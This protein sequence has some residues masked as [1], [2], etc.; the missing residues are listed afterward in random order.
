MG[1]AKNHVRAF[2]EDNLRETRSGGIPGGEII[3]SQE[4]LLPKRLRRVDNPPAG[5]IHRRQFILGRVPFPVRRDWTVIQLSQGLFFSHCPELEVLR[6]R[7]RR[8][9]MWM[10][11][12]NAFQTD[13]AKTSPA[14]E[15]ANSIT[16]EQVREATYSWTGRWVLI[17]E[18]SVMTDAG[19]LLGVYYV[20]PIKGEVIGSSSLS[21]LKKHFGTHT[22]SRRL[23]GWYGMNWF[24]PPLT[25]IN[26]VR[27]LLPDQILDLPMCSVQF[28]ER[29]K[30]E[31]FR[32]WGLPDRAQMIASHLEHAI[33][34]IGVHYPRVFLALTAGLDSRS[35]LSCLGRTHGSTE[36]YTMRHPLISKA[37]QTIPQVLARLCNISHD[38]ILP[39]V[40]DSKLAEIYDAHTLRTAFDADR[41]FYVRSMFHKF[42]RDAAL[43]RSGCWEIGRNF[44]YK[45]FRELTWADVTEDSKLIPRRF[46]VFGNLSFNARCLEEWI[47][48]RSQ[49]PGP[50]DWKDLF[51]RDQRLCGWLSSIEQ[52]L[53]LIDARSLH[54]FNCSLFYDL[55][56]GVSETA[57]GSGEIQRL[58]IKQAS[59]D[60]WT[61]PIN[62]NIDSKILG[63]LQTLRHYANA[64]ARELLNF[65]REP[66]WQPES[67]AQ[68]I[69]K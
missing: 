50:Y 5:H 64:G 67:A 54:P 30:P 22:L 66:L 27:K 58:L 43:L 28:A 61:I 16:D 32:R 45:H 60:L 52:S 23:L 19:G 31:Q 44:Y 59:S 42:E 51:Y 57:R 37:D 46:K 69:S 2:A 12:G 11:V 48:W 65:T 10:I 55:L 34:Q 24:P 33:E 36:A 39:K 9:R 3:E 13:P 35:T 68:N 25:P 62:P 38:Y 40:P 6:V 53:D 14:E 56:L 4:L 29:H 17:S 41:Y 7:D 21:L 47:H 63:F 18:S 15:I 26:G 49:H 1:T 20:S 8:Q